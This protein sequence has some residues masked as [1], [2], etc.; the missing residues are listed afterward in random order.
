MSL[1]FGVFCSGCLLDDRTSPSQPTDQSMS[2]KQFY[3][4]MNLLTKEE[5]ARLKLEDE[6]SQLKKELLVTQ[7]GVTT[8]YHTYHQSNETLSMELKT[9][10]EDMSKMVH[11]YSNL[12]MKYDLVKAEL[13]E[14]KLNS[15][16]ISYY[17]RVL[18]DEIESIKHLK[19]MADLQAI[20]NIAIKANNIEHEL[21][22]T[23]TKLE[24]VV[25]DLDARK[26]DLIALFN[27]GDK[28]E[29]A[30]NHSNSEISMLKLSQ[31][32]SSSI[33]EKEVHSMSYR[34]SYIYCFSCLN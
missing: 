12:Q 3:M 7:Q 1:N 20:I 32:I 6:I 10:K 28:M 24:S 26:Q 31:N 19:I 16:Q 17:A 23:K 4:L 2:D 33:L 22:T 11:N 9:M 34:G 30:L 15:T 29:T 27:N 13:N 21:N 18:E 5:N 25:H 14:V 8:N